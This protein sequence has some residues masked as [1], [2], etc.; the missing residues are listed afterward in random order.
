MNGLS[1]GTVDLP[2]HWSTTV[3]VGAVA[4]GSRRTVQR[5]AWII[6]LESNA[7]EHTVST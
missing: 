2:F 4:V 5:Q 6:A 3:G 1:V 7:N